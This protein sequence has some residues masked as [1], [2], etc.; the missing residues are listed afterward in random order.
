MPPSYLTL[1]FLDLLC[2]AEDIDAAKELSKIA[3]IDL[4]NFKAM[5]EAVIIKDKNAARCVLYGLRSLELVDIR[6]V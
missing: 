5:F 4:T 6:S 1:L 3:E 2:T